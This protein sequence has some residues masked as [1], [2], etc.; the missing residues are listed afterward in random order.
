[1]VRAN[2]D[3]VRRGASVGGGF[4]RR[5]SALILVLGALALITVLAAVYLTIGASDTRTAQAVRATAEQAQVEQE[6]ADHIA[7]VIGQDRLDTYPEPSLLGTPSTFARELF[8]Y[9]STDWSVRS[10]TTDA[11]SYRRASASGRHVE[12]W[13]GGGRDLRV[14]SDPWLAS[15]RPTFL[16]AS[17]LFEQGRRDRRF[18]DDRDWAQISA[19]APDMRFVNLFNLLPFEAQGGLGTLSGSR[20]G[21]DAEPGIDFYNDANG[22]RRRR[23]SEGLSLLRLQ[24]PG[25]K[26]SRIQAFD[27]VPGRVAWVPGFDLPQGVVLDDNADLRNVPAVW[28]SNQRYLAMPANQ[29]FYILDRAGRFADWSSPDYPAYQYADAD[30][31]GVYDARWIELTD[32]RVDGVIRD[33]LPFSRKDLR[34][35]VAARVEDLSARI[36][37]NTATDLLSPPTVDHPLG[38]TPADIDLRRVL[39]MEDTALEFGIG[40]GELDHPDNDADPT[41]VYKEYETYDW[42]TLNF[43][44]PA[45]SG[46]LSG[47]LLQEMTASESIGALAYDAVRLALSRGEAMDD[48]YFGPGVPSDFGTFGTEA[49]LVLTPASRFWYTFD[50]PTAQWVDQG[51]DERRAEARAESFLDA[52]RYAR[53]ERGAFRSS[54]DEVGPIGV[55]DRGDL[56]ELLTYRGVNDPRVTGRLEQVMMGRADVTLRDPPGAQGTRQSTRRLSPLL[57]NRPLEIDRLGFGD[58]RIRTGYDALSGTGNFTRYPQVTGLI[59]EEMFLMQAVSPRLSLTTL[60]GAARLVGGQPVTMQQATVGGQIKNVAPSALSAAEAAVSVGNLATDVSSGFRLAAR[61]LARDAGIANA[62]GTKVAWMDDLREAD[63]AQSLFAPRETDTLFLGESGP[64]LALR[65]AAHWAVNAKDMFDGSDGVNEVTAATL[66]L[67]NGVIGFLDDSGDSGLLGE[68]PFPWWDDTQRGGVLDAGQ[69]ALRGDDRSGTGFAPE[70][71]DPLRAAVNVFGTEAMPVLTEAAVVSVYTDAFTAAGGDVDNNRHDTVTNFVTGEQSCRPR[72]VGSLKFL[73]LSTTPDMRNNTDMLA[74]A[75]VFQLHNPHD[76]AISLGGSGLGPDQVLYD[77]AS[78][79]DRFSYYIEYAG[80]FYKLGGYADYELDGDATDPAS[81]IAVANQN[82]RYTNVV[83]GPGQTRNFFALAV[84]DDDFQPAVPGE[85]GDDDDFSLIEDRWWANLEAA[86]TS[87][88][89]FYNGSLADVGEDRNPFTGLA[90]E[91]LLEQL[92]IGGLAPA[93]VREFNPASGE[94]VRRPDS[95]AATIARLPKGGNPASGDVSA[96]VSN[97]TQNRTAW[98]SGNGPELRMEARASVDVV[99][100]WRKMENTGEFQRPF[101][102]GQPGQTRDNILANDLL[103]D[104]LHGAAE[105]ARTIDGGAIDN[106]VSFEEGFTP[107]CGDLR[108]NDNTGWTIAVWG[109]VRKRDGSGDELVPGGLP[110]WM[111]SSRSDGTGA[112]AVGAPKTG[113]P[114][115]VLEMD[116]VRTFVP[117]APAISDFDDLATGDLSGALNG[118]ASRNREF[119]TTLSRFSKTG[120]DGKDDLD[121]TI[122]VLPFSVAPGAQLQKVLGTVARAPGTKFNL[123]SDGDKFDSGSAELSN[124]VAGYQFEFDEAYDPRGTQFKPRLPRTAIGTARARPADALS[125]LAVGAVQVPQMSG[126]GAFVDRSNAGQDFDPEREWLTQAEMLALAFGYEDAVAEDPG[127]DVFSDAAAYRARL[128][129]AY[130]GL[131]INKGSLSLTNIDGTTIGWVSALD[132]GKLPID[133]GAAYLDRGVDRVFDAASDDRRGLGVPPALALLSGVRLDHGSGQA[134]GAATDA[135]TNAI[136]GT[137]NINTVPTMLARALPGLSPSIEWVDPDGSA[138][139][140]LPRKNWLTLANGSAITADDLGVAID[141][142]ADISAGTPASFQDTPD[143]A[144]TLI[145]YRDR[146][147]AEHRLFSDVSLAAGGSPVEEFLLDYRPVS[148]VGASAGDQVANQMA[149]NTQDIGRSLTTGLDAVREQRGLASSGEMLAAVA[150]A[151]DDS[152]TP[153]VNEG[154]V[155]LNQG[156]NTMTALGLDGLAMRVKDDATLAGASQIDAGGDADDVVDELEERVALANAALASTDVRSD[157]FAVWMLVHAYTPED[158]SGLRPGDP[159]VPGFSR[160]YVMVLDRSN[161][162]SETDRPRIVLFQAV[163]E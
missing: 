56:A 148:L 122:A 82:E 66:A 89:N 35:F 160:R 50:E 91:W 96:Y 95:S 25:D 1:M 5:G 125:A 10:T 61:S 12:P 15:T 118:F 11:L 146:R 55:F 136:L 48:R 38:L 103:V 3:P 137:V 2:S 109:S 128:D 69:A 81:W 99:R 68:Q 70:G 13:L 24:A 147:D 30:G 141:P 105:L 18:L 151:R 157:F 159:L 23:M 31:D 144:A 80:R 158:V 49:R 57:S 93:R 42:R 104:R 33:L 120:F 46:V 74:Q 4:V 64:E 100:L 40:L 45:V 58:G 34:V 90:E 156:F 139:S 43:S 14:A 71:S 28:A 19:L 113:S 27:P 110:A 52:G 32:T 78:R 135:R 8:D 117:G 26:A 121:E 140:L 73:T 36:N 21:F 79:S 53:H 17:R 130:A 133:R 87:V 126:P 94:L 62:G 132:S 9:P 72:E 65:L 111:I 92:S 154:R 119:A 41:S 155:I 124:Q 37:V 131:W 134:S 145:A 6:V 152:S 149:N 163:P 44:T 112:S 115:E 63:P 102:S 162:V 54:A 108:R 143:A 123:A 107:P 114:Y 16:G 101:N 59:D 22:A 75:I 39:T 161:V 150:S 67:D 86:G 47:A 153:A 129:D 76:Q 97:L 60:S 29:A 106:T 138:G 142:D 127:Q 20:G 83:L 116:D 88:G 84:Q 7:E 51:D 77:Q 85:T 98:P